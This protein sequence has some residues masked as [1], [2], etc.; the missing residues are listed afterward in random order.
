[1]Y[2]F[3]FFFFFVLELLLCFFFFFSSRRRH[4]RYIG[5]WSS[6]VCSSDLA[7]MPFHRGVR[8]GLVECDLVV[9]G[10]LI[11]ARHGT[12]PQYEPHFLK[13]RREF[14]KV[15]G[16]LRVAVPLDLPAPLLKPFLTRDFRFDL[17]GGL[18]HLGEVLLNCGDVALDRSRLAALAE[19]GTN[20][21]RDCDRKERAA[22]K[23]GEGRGVEED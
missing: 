18:R 2:T 22:Y 5:D 14:A 3:F 8:G 20:A 7:A 4:T 17:L 21:C 13:K 1:M 15:L 6:D 9:D 11:E 19:E 12:A 23:D 16:E 10:R